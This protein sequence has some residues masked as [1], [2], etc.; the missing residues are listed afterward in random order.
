VYGLKR[1]SHAEAASI[2]LDKYL[3]QSTKRH[4]CNEYCDSVTGQ[5]VGLPFQGWGTLYIDHIIRHLCGLEPTTNGFQFHPLSTR[6]KSLEVRNIRI[7]D[8]QVSVKAEQ[9]HWLVNIDG[10]VAI[11][12]P[13]QGT[14]TA[15]VED[16]KLVIT[17]PAE[18]QVEQAPG[19]STPVE[20]RNVN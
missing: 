7:G 18:L 12:A 3:A 20:I 16:G 2:I 14:F 6:Y 11:K 9:G 19:Q 15:V 5:D 17:G 4:F 10:Q 13:S 1:N 8:M